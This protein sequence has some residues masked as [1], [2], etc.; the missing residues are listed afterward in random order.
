MEIWE[1]E[2]D[3]LTD[4]DVEDLG[5]AQTRGRSLPLI[6]G[7][8]QVSRLQ[9]GGRA[10]N[11]DRGVRCQRGASGARMKLRSMSA[12]VVICLIWSP[13][14]ATATADAVT[15]GSPSPAAWGRLGV[16]RYEGPG[17][18]DDIPSAVDISPDGRTAF[19]TGSSF[20]AD[21]TGTDYATLAYSTASGAQ[22]WLTRY[23]GLAHGADKGTD[24]AVSPDGARVY[25]TGESSRLGGSNDGDFVTIAYD[26]VTG[27][28]LWLARFDGPGQYTD[29]AKRIALSTDGTRLYVGGT[30]VSSTTRVEDYAAV[31]YEAATGEQLWA[32]LYDGF[33]EGRD[34]LT[35]LALS[36]DGSR[37]YATGQSDTA[38]PGDNTDY[39]TVAYG[40]ATGA[41]I[42]RQRYDGSSAEL[43]TAL[44]VGPDGNRVYV[45]GLS[46]TSRWFDYVTVAYGAE[47]G[48]QLAVTAYDGAFNVDIPSDIGVSPDG[49]RVYVTGRS[50]G[51]DDR[52]D[53]YA[54]V[55]YDATLQRQLWASRYDGGSRDVDEAKAL[56][57]SPD[58]TRIYVTGLSDNQEVS[59]ADCATVAYSAATGARVGVDRFDGPASGSDAATDLVVSPNGRR[60]YVT[61]LTQGFDYD[62]DYATVAYRVER[63]PAAG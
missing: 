47:S 15:H 42:W 7:M 50:W 51:G 27:S 22:L 9:S 39:A 13:A 58:G 25:V 23:D 17:D 10:S 63:A 6:R 54:T 24:L 11:S 49:T 37:L 55:A 28:Q 21:R 14:I 1:K 46:E 41:E 8:G 52:K 18:R 44:A 33:V 43:P 2:T 36:A 3:D 59:Y 20:S 62:F 32:S 31:A 40:T 26:A 4:E 57:V 56:G 35:D 12:V 30:S 19:V 29:Q 61:G 34:D 38:L 53:D 16:V 48:I 5:G 45:T 60:V